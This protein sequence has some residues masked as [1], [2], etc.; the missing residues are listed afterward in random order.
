VCCVLCVRSDISNRAEE[1]EVMWEAVSL[2]FFLTHTII[3]TQSNHVWVTIVES[4]LHSNTS[5]THSRQV[6]L[7]FCSCHIQVFPRYYS[8]FHCRQMNSMLS[9]L[10]IKQLDLGSP[11]LSLCQSYI[12]NGI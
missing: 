2:F 6:F 8:F 4:L 10:T 7:L 9:T 5:P 1:C 12:M 11:Q 3:S